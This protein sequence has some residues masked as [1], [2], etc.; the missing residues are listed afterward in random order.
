M[1][2][3]EGSCPDRGRLNASQ[4]S[5]FGHLL[6]VPA[7]ALSENGFEIGWF[8]DSGIKV[9][10]Q[11]CHGNLKYL[12]NPQEGRNGDRT[13][14][15]DLLPV[16]RRESERDHVFLRVTALLPKVTYLRTQSAE[17]L[18]LIRHALVCMVLRAV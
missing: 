3:S 14:R 2:F 10:H 12:A 13:S 18:S 1:K 17:E 11:I 5:T 8:I 4:G 7:A 15:L 9:A 6:P 16:P